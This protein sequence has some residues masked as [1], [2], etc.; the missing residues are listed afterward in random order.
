MV[1]ALL[2][3]YLWWCAVPLVVGGIAALAW[4]AHRDDRAELD[5]LALAVGDLPSEDPDVTG[6][7]G[8]TPAEAVSPAATDRD[9]PDAEPAP[10][11][12]PG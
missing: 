7:S 10:L 2:H 9:T 6:P 3:G 5:W 12:V 11:D 8:G 1:A 4:R